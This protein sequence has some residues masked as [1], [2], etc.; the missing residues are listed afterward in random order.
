M[1]GPRSLPLVNRLSVGVTPGLS[2][3]NAAIAVLTVAPSAWHARAAC[4]VTRGDSRLPLPNAVS[5]ADSA[6]RL[7]EA[8]A[9]GDK[10]SAEINV[11]SAANTGRSAIRVQTRSVGSI[12]PLSV[13]DPLKSFVITPRCISHLQ[14]TSYQANLPFLTNL[15]FHLKPKDIGFNASSI[16]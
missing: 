16:R 15:T 11:K 12:V 3:S 13:R 6:L 14:P 1:Y 4:E 5:P 8:E 10:R 9:S 2:A 7:I